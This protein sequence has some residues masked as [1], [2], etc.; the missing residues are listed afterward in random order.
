MSFEAVV[1]WAKDGSLWALALAIVVV[2][3]WTFVGIGHMGVEWSKNA[4]LMQGGEGLL[5][6]YAAIAGESLLKVAVV[7]AFLYFGLLRRTAPER[8]LSYFVIMLIIPIA[9]QVAL[10][11]MTMAGIGKRQAETHTAASEISAAM[12][13][14]LADGEVDRGVV[15][16]GDAGKLEVIYKALGADLAA[17][18]RGFRT[19]I[20]VL[21]VPYAMEPRY[22]AEPGGLARA[23]AKIMRARELVAKYRALHNSRTDRA[24]RWIETSSIKE[25][26]KTAALAEL[27]TYLAGQEARIDKALDRYAAACTE[28]EGMVGVLERSKGHWRATPD[29]IGFARRSDLEAYRAHATKA[30]EIEG[31]FESDT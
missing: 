10:M 27:D 6:N 24:R 8:G 31:S 20:D 7:W 22:L 15:Q 28:L 23:R 16:T 3:L 26:R 25:K 11:H 9:A 12:A 21:A 13:D 30:R 17:N 19:E 1:K 2:L 14:A 4:W 5:M 18:Q 29:G